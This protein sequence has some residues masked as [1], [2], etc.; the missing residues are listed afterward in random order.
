[1]R[2]S[3][4]LKA[5]AYKQEKATL[6]LPPMDPPHMI[7]HV[8]DATKHPRTAG[9]LARHAGVVFR[10]VAVAVLLAGEAALH[11]LRTALVA[12]EEMFPV[13]V[14]VL[15]QVAAAAEDGLRRAAGVG[16]APG[17]VGV[18]HAVVGEVFLFGA[19]GRGG[20]GGG[21]GLGQRA[22]GREGRMGAAAVEGGVHVGV[23]EVVCGRGR[24]PLL[25]EGREE[26]GVGGGGGGGGGEDGIERVDGAGED[27]LRVEG[28]VAL[29]GA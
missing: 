22:G 11:G 4:F 7:L 13:A 3:I 21:G 26:R 25:V 24:N 1:M 6:L 2:H 18:L 9:P 16:A 8:V 29:V 12:A 27:G 15:A 28:V 17:A 20:L 23:E 5:H 14:V 10:L 19:A